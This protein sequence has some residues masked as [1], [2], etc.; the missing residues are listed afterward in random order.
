MC[1]LEK[2]RANEITEPLAFTVCKLELRGSV[3]HVPGARGL[4]VFNYGQ[5]EMK[6]TSFIRTKTNQ[7]ASAAAQVQGGTRFSH[8]Q[9]RT[10]QK[11]KKNVLP[12]KKKKPRR[13]CCSVVSKMQGGICF[14][15]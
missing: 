12:Q 9:Q 13:K 6:A 4:T 10:K 5:N 14:V 7:G 15:Q 1:Q 11:E 8:G 3:S 2:P